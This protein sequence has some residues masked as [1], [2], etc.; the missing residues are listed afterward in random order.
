MRLGLPAAYVH[1]LPQ[2][3]QPKMLAG[4]GSL[5]AYQ[6]G[7]VKFLLS[8]VNNRVNGILADEMV[9]LYVPALLAVGCSGDVMSHVTS[10]QTVCMGRPIT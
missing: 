10:I 2:V 8:L 4:A 9:Q 6:L 7:G 3:A 1:W 5:R